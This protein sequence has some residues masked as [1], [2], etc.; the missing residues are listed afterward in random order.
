MYDTLD[1]KKA[2]ALKEINAYSSNN[3]MAKQLQPAK[4]CY[5]IGADKCQD[6]SCRLVKEYLGR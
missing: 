6:T 5:C 3:T 4:Q 1:N 2:S